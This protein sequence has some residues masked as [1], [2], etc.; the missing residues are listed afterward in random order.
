MPCA[1]SSD[2]NDFDDFTS[3]LTAELTISY[4]DEITACLF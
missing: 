3:H 2:T 1:G 4:K